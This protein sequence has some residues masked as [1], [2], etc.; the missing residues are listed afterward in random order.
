M[1]RRRRLP[2]GLAVLAGTLLHGALAYPTIM[3]QPKHCSTLLEEGSSIM[4]APAFLSK[5][6]PPITVSHAGWNHG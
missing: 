2:L 5:E 4:G 3:L 1:S 6:D